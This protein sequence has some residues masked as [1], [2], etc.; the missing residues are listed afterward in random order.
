MSLEEFFEKDDEPVVEL[1][2]SVVELIRR[3]RLQLIIHSA[4]Y[5]HFNSNIVNDGQYDA[6]TK[7]LVEL[8]DKYP[9]Y[10]DRH[11]KYFKD[12]RGETGFHFP[13][14]ED[15]LAKAH[16]LLRVSEIE[17]NMIESKKS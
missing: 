7:E 17:K 6:W 16:A 11:D 15:V 8:H 10:S 5:Y 3:R 1:D 9:S 12:W 2:E 13:K 4:I 14:D